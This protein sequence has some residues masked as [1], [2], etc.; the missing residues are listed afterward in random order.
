MKTPDKNLVFICLLAFTLLFHATGGAARSFDASAAATMVSNTDNKEEADVPENGSPEEGE[1]EEPDPGEGEAPEEGEP[2]EGEPEEGEPEE[3]EPP[4]E[5]EP[6]L[7][8]EPPGEAGTLVAVDLVTPKGDVVTAAG[9]ETITLPLVASVSIHE[10]DLDPNRIAVMF[11]I[12]DLPYQAARHEDGFFILNV[13]ADMPPPDADT[14]PETDENDADDT[15]NGD[16]EEEEVSEYV[17]AVQALAY[18][19]ENDDI[20][21]ESPVYTIELR[22][23][24]DLDGNGFVDNPFAA[25]PNPGDQWQA[26]VEG[27]ECTRLIVMTPMVLDEGYTPLFLQNPA[28]PEQVTSVWAPNALIEPEEYGIL[29]AATACSPEDLYWPYETGAMRASEPGA[30]TQDGAYTDISLIVS[31]DQGRTFDEVTPLRLAAHPIYAMFGRLTE[32]DGF[33]TLFHGFPTMVDSDVIT[34]IRVIPLSGQWMTEGVVDLGKPYPGGVHSVALHR[35]YALAPFEMPYPGEL[36]VE[37]SPDVAYNYGVVRVDHPAT[38]TFVLTNIGGET[39]QC[40]IVLDDEE[41]MFFVQGADKVVLEPE[42]THTLK[43]QFNPAEAVEYEATLSFIGGENSPQHITLVGR[44]SAQEKS[45]QPLGCGASTPG[46]G[47]GIMEILLALVVAWAL[48]RRS[49]TEASGDVPVTPSE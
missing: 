26:L 5:G 37:P 6:P 21:V 46:R 7:D 32:R 31:R 27:P 1:Q 34:G 20:W 11:A 2:E 49:K 9:V 22:T 35:L 47:F 13:K 43:V 36:A 30:L 18:D 16:D 45:I 38:A 48:F 29:I 40:E 39:L 42:D 14:P 15:D 8:E 33:Q 28:Y 23:A 25:L 44:G 4:V 19:K 24:D 10:G 3:G 12:N 41:G 17:F